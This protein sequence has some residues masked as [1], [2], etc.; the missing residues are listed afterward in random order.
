MQSTFKSL[1]HIASDSIIVSSLGEYV[2]P[3]GLV[4]WVEGLLRH[5]QGFPAGA[6][7]GTLTVDTLRVDTSRQEE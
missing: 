1:P 6:I 7:H 5:S 2:D 3:A 4:L